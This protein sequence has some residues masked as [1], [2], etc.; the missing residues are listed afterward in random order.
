MVISHRIPQNQ[1]RREK[2]QVKTLNTLYHLKIKATKVTVKK[3]S[4]PRICFVDPE[5][6]SKKTPEQLESDNSIPGAE[7]PK[8]NKILF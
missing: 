3:T 7:G 5:P 6:Q 4:T 2:K 1:Q 8:V